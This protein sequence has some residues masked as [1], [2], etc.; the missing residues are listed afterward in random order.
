[1][2]FMEIFNNVMTTATDIAVAS[3]SGGQPNVRLMSF[4]YDSDQKG[5]IYI[6]TF[7]GSTKTLE[8]SANC[9]AAFSTIPAEN[10]PHVR[11]QIACC[12]KSVLSLDDIKS[13]Y[14]EKNPFFVEL[15]EQMGSALEVWEITFKEADIIVD[16]QNESKITL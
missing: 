7:A 4:F 14:L 11:A 12:K 15:F 13:K 10:G 2:N 6:V 16:M 5:V 9:K 1:M 8:F 3:E